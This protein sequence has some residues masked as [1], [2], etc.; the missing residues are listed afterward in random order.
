LRRYR[1]VLSRNAARR[2][3]VSPLLTRLVGNLR[4]GNMTRKHYEKIAKAISEG[5]DIIVLIETLMDIFED[6]NPR[7]DREK[8]LI[9]CRL[10]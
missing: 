5:T 1:K 8:F 7:F 10:K 6:D 3:A 4:G 2:R 9:A